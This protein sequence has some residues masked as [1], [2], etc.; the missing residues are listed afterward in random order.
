M[1]SRPVPHLVFSHAYF[2][3]RPRQLANQISKLPAILCG[4]H[5]L[6]D[7]PLKPDNVRLPH[8]CAK[9]QAHC[10]GGHDQCQAQL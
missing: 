10:D 9:H 3:A 6:D 2:K 4:P 8:D 1:G 7:I 5:P